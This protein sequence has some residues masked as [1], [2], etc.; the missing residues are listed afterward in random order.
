MVSLQLDI[1]VKT[2]DEQ[3]PSGICT[4]TNYDLASLLGAGTAG[5]NAPAASLGVT[6][7]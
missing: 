1:W 4:G 7:S 2:G 3:G 5:L 6:P